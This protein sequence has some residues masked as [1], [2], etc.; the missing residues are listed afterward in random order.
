MTL[1]QVVVLT[2]AGHVRSGRWLFI[3][4]PSPGS[5]ICPRV[6]IYLSYM[7]VNT[8]PGVGSIVPEQRSL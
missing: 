4:I 6:L 8:V 2:P 5:Y 3:A 7:A 1:F